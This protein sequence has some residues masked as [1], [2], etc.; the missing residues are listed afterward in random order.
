MT[1]GLPG[2]RKVSER[3]DGVS[4]SG[5]TLHRLKAALSP[6]WPRP[7]VAIGLSLCPLAYC[8]MKGAM[9]A[10]LW[11]DEIL[12]FNLERFPEGRA[13]E[14]GRPGSF[15]PRLIGPFA[16]ADL[17]RAVHALFDALGFHLSTNPELY[18]RLPSLAFF[19]VSVAALYFIALRTGGDKL[20]AAGVALAFGSTPAFLFYAFEARVYSLA[21]LLVIA[22]LAVLWEILEGERGRTL[23]VGTILGLVVVWAH[24]WDVCLLL[25]VG[26]GLPVIAWRDAEQWR[27]AARV[28]LVI[29]L[30][31]TF[32][33]IQKMY[34]F[35]LRVPGQRGILLFDPQP[36]KSVFYSTVYG[37]FLGLLGGEPEYVLGILLAIAL[38][39]GRGKHGWCVPAS[40]WIA[41][42]LSVGLMSRYGW[43][44]SPRHQT[45]F[46]A[47]VFVSL[48]LT[49]AGLVSK[50]LLANLIGLNL[51][52][53]PMTGDRI[54][55]KGNA[56]QI[57]RVIGSGERL[58]Q[59]P[60]IVQHSYTIG[61]P[62]PLHTFALVFYL[63]D[64]EPRQPGTPILEL[65]THRDV[66]D[67]RLDREYFMNGPE[68]LAIFA[69][70]PV[71]AWVEFLK[72]L[73]DK[74]VWLVGPVGPRNLVQQ[75]KYASALKAA[76]FSRV[77]GIPE[78][79]GGYPTT[80]LSL[81]KRWSG[82]ATR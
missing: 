68:K 44:V 12:Y 62:D 34:I 78:E 32:V 35:S 74:A 9:G 28:A 54:Q 24:L 43:G 36:L 81:W 48:A 40:T 37:P 17:Q 31:L 79:F 15:W 72:N 25:A 8:L 57:A 76:G 39:R 38:F 55:D 45:P 77:R 26:V 7:A 47:A 14:L 56:K 52:L 67:I 80:R 13:M 1:G 2:N 50:A 65:P 66:R 63:D 75:R 11:L 10:S 59:F 19:A 46:Y 20:W 22:F 41:L 82:E 4:S 30:G 58:R 27:K 71:A 29:G 64:L 3:V 21:A 61:Y 18:L 42:A 49:R 69:E 73:P 5:W 51:V 53:L 23:A 16:Y 70:S 33:W 6:G 60:V